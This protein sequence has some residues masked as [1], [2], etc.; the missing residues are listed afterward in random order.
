MGVLASR[1]ILNANIQV[2]TVYDI[3]CQMLFLTLWDFL[4]IRIQMMNRR[5]GTASTIAGIKF[6]YRIFQHIEFR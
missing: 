1:H 6:F 3:G 5:V 4:V 2:N